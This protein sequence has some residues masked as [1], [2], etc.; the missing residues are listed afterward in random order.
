MLGE[1]REAFGE[2]AVIAH[3]RE[4]DNAAG[5]VVAMERL[6]SGGGSGGGVDPLFAT[7]RGEMSGAI[8]WSG[9]FI[10]QAGIFKS[11]DA[12]ETPLSGDHALDK[13]LFDGGG[14]LE[15]VPEGIEKPVE[16]LAGFVGED[17]GLSEEAV[18]GAVARGF[19]LAL[20]SGGAKGFGSVGAGGG[21]LFI[22]T[23]LLA[24]ERHG[25]RGY[26]DAWLVRG[27]VGKRV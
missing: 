16:A 21:F 11:Q 8:R 22:G 18:L 5:T 4:L 9:G 14:G 17:K 20:R 3:F 13:D 10:E 26:C 7:G 1:L 2:L 24:F 27:W 23:F 6:E 15:L 19:A 25:L 12:H